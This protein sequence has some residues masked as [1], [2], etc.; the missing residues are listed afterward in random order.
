MD[1][2]FHKPSP[3]GYSIIYIVRLYLAKNSGIPL[4]S[5]QNHKM[6]AVTLKA[7]C[8]VFYWKTKK[9]ELK[10]MMAGTTF[11]SFD[12]SIIIKK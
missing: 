5:K 2:S 8:W 1:D 9:F 11:I 7:K 3:Y 12:R 10:E 6:K 4:F